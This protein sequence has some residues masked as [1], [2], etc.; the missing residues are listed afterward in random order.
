MVLESIRLYHRDWGDHKGRYVGNVKF[1]NAECSI[2]INLDP[3]TADK[4]I[5]LLANQVVSAAKGTASMLVSE[6]LESSFK[7]LVEGKK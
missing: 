1:T 4:V 2:D 7:G 6:V 5:K 3:D